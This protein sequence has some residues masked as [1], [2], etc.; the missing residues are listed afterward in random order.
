MFSRRNTENGILSNFVKILGAGSS[1]KHTQR[2]FSLTKE[3]KK[4]F[5]MH[6]LMEQ[7]SMRPSNSVCASNL[8]SL[9]C[10]EDSSS[11]AS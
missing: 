6:D 7:K 5:W 4:T 8:P 9:E 2:N 1:P 10:L 3:I 11:P